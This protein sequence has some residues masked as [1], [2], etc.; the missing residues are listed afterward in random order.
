MIYGNVELFNTEQII[1]RE[2]V[3]GKVLNRFSSHAIAGLDRGEDRRG[4]VTQAYG[5][6]IE[7]RFVSQSDTVKVC[8]GAWDNDGYVSVSNGDYDNCTIYLPQGEMK[9]IILE[10]HPRLKLVEAPGPERFSRDVWRITYLK[11]FTPVF[12]YA[13]GDGIRPPEPYEIPS[14]TMLAYGSSITFGA[15]TGPMSAQTHMQLLARKL[16]IQVMNKSMPGSCFCE[17]SYGDYLSGISADYYYYELGG[18]MRL[19]HSPEE[20]K[21][22]ATHIVA[23]TRRKNPKAPIILLTVYPLLKCIPDENNE[24][25]SRVIEEYDR[26]LMKLSGN[27]NIHLV[28]STGILN[29][30][31]LLSFDGLHPSGYGNI[32]MAD[33]IYDKIKHIVQVP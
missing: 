10:R 30:T 32:V 5:N 3:P 31:R 16:G 11:R 29:D 15:G 8:I 25:A 14:K 4:P 12:S 24:K 19:R 23:E 27:D 20:F 9:T 7:I 17:L 22:R 13:E 21:K 33:N 6:E 28:D 18:N 26:T 2:G 1:G